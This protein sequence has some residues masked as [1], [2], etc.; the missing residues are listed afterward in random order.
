[1]LER[2]ARVVR[3]FHDGPAFRGRFVAGDVVRAYVAA[4]G[5]RNVVLPEETPRALTV[6]AEIDDA[7]GEPAEL[8]SCH[9]DLLPA[10]LIDVAGGLR[11]IDWEYAA[12]GDPY[13]D[14]GN[15]AA[16]LELD[17]E[18][19]GRFLECYLRRPP[20]S[21]ERE[22]LAKSRVLSDLREGAW[23]LMQTGIA[24]I[25]FDFLAYAKKHL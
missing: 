14:L 23:G 18:S 9:N 19:A 20:T 10:N 13:F 2:V 25:D 8:K 1:T 4:A 16:N 6:L 15:F 7:L 17:A 11:V 5:A 22:R 3:K 24:D 12:M 21:K